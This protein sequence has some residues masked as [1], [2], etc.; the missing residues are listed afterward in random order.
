MAVKT[1]VLRMC[2]V[3]RDK[4]DKREMLRIVKGLEGEFSIDDAYKK[5]GRSAYI[6][7][8]L[9]CIEKCFKIKALNRSFSMEVPKEIYDEL[10]IKVKS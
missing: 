7:K 9:V 4:K 10:K 6:C 5:N 2:C 1:P 8:N 3:C